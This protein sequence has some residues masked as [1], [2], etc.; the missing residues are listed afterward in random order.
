MQV[1]PL[2]PDL[3]LPTSEIR[4][5]GSGGLRT[6]GEGRGPVSKRCGFKETRHEQGRRDHPLRLYD[7]TFPPDYQQKISVPA[8]VCADGLF[9]V[10]VVRLL[11]EEN[12]VHA[13]KLL[14]VV[15]ADELLGVVLVNF[16]A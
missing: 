12:L 2:S 3:S 7:T 15:H 16:D 13:L 5:S 1:G 8:G 6:A 11:V 9:L 10:L 4:R 14:L